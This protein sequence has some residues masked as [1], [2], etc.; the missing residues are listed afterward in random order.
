M[1]TDQVVT[2]VEEKFCKDCK[3][4]IGVRY[5]SELNNWNCGHKLNDL[6]FDQP[7]LVTGIS[8]RRFRISIYNLR[9]PPLHYLAEGVL[10]CGEG[11]KWFER[12]EPPNDIVSTLGG[13]EAT[14][15]AFDET[16]LEAGKAAAKA[17]LE[18]LRARKK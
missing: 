12:Y 2:V 16:A 13:Q 4:L 18:A 5:K 7:H 10:V 8:K 14:E 15:V 11:G 9:Y 1:D 6:G 3:H 17:R